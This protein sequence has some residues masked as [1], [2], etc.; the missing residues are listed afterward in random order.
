MSASRLTAAALAHKRARGEYTG[1]ATR[2]GYRRQGDF[3]VID[4]EELRAI[5]LAQELRGAGL[6]LRA[7]SRELAAQGYYNRLGKPFG[8]SQVKR[9]CQSTVAPKVLGYTEDAD[10]SREIAAALG[11]S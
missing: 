8:A 7:V 2:Y 11:D 4:T 1:G 9:L 3:E 5:G 10:R 6:S